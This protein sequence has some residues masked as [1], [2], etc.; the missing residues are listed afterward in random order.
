MHPGSAY[1]SP[2]VARERVRAELDAIDA[3]LTRLRESVTDEVGNA[4]RIELAD[5]LE[6]QERMNRGLM[7]RIFREI[8][9][10][11]DGPDD[12]GLPSGVKVRD[13]LRT[14]LRITAGEVRRRMRVAARIRPRRSLSGPPAAPELAALADA[15]EAGEVGEDHIR[16]VCRAMDWLP[17]VVD[18][19]GR[20]KAEKILV[21][22]AKVED[23]QFVTAVGRILAEELNPEEFFDDADR[24][25]RRGL[26]LG[27]QGPD[28]MSKLSGYL[29]PEARAYFE[30][31]VAAVRPGHHLPESEQPTVNAKTD[32][33]TK[34]QRLHDAFA[35]GLRT[36]LGSGQLGTHRGLPVTVIT[37]TTLAELEQ[38]AA[39]TV[40]PNVPMPGPARTGGGSPLPMRDLIAM[41]ADS[42]HYLVVFENHSARPIYLARSRR[43]ATPD[44]R[45]ICYARDR[46]CTHP[47]CDE[48]GYHAEVHHAPV[49]FADGGPTD[50]D[51]LFFAC[52]PSHKAATDGTY[53]TEISD[54]GRLAW[55]DGTRPPEV[56]RLHHPEELLE[57]DPDD[58]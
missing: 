26:V 49:D 9:D 41:A 5:R 53:R 52:G 24:Q 48:P 20:A 55:T 34:T 56:N 46:G 36:A 33:R 21:R 14:R 16:E 23:H 37:T 11:P 17:K 51:R 25:N 57:G 4:F 35:W 50:A 15:V 43:F 8:A 40:D 45:I 44:Q 13:L 54:A 32:I 19:E 12:T 58:P 38:A 27:R 31:V 47:G 22:H 29:T 6:V 10:P 7:Y 30:A 42:I 3:A 18:A 2:D 28:G 39:A 1:V